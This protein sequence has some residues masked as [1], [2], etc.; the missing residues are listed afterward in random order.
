MAGTLR[1]LLEGWDVA[2][3]GRTGRPLGEG[4]EILA[5]TP[6][7]DDPHTI[8]AFSLGTNDSPNPDALEAAVRE[9]MGYL[10]A[11]GCVI[12]ATIA[13]P[14]MNG[15]SYRADNQRLL[16]LE[17]DPQ[18]YG[19]LLVVPWQREYAAH[20]SWRRPDGV[21]ATPEGYAARAQLYAD[22]ARGCPA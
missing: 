17:A 4:M 12:R 3:D 16:D 13:R 6:I 20:K 1:G 7:P 14:P 22:A 11:H 5:E 19:R 15:V 10:G 18:L 21:H 2:V 8:L 9:S